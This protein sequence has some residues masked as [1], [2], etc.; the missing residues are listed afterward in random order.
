MFTDLWGP[1]SLTHSSF[2]DDAIHD[3]LSHTERHGGIL[4]K[5]SAYIL[6]TRPCLAL[7]V[8]SA[9]LNLEG[10]NQHCF[11]EEI[12]QKHSLVIPKAVQWEQDWQGP[13]VGMTSGKQFISGDEGPGL[14]VLFSTAVLRRRVGLWTDSGT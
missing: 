3:L 11:K 4:S 13:G 14:E 12:G 9:L 2:S 8:N 10:S 7:D 1:I 5:L 6:I